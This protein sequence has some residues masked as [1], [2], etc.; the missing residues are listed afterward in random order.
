MIHQETP[1]EKPEILLHMC[2][3]PCATHA[4][5]MLKGDFRVTGLFYGPN[6]HPEIEY[7]MRL[8]E[9]ER[10]AETAGIEMIRA[11]YDMTR[12]FESVEG[13]ESEEE[14]GERCSNCCRMR[15]EK[16]AEYAVEKGIEYFTTTLSVSPHKDSGD[17]N[18][19]GA[20]IAE[21][22]GLTYYHA[23]FKKKDG[24]KKSV[25]ISRKLGLYRQDYCGCV[26]SRR[27]RDSRNR[28]IK[29]K[30]DQFEQEKG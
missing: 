2:C 17:I 4:V 24:F 7:I 28:S 27:D 12:W 16:T 5:E 25:D 11:E 19:S 22:L 29:K 18:D 13:L 6:I 15:L 3:A 20:E 1:G 10:F 23:D 30:L 14:G 21:R 8:E 26:F 9:A